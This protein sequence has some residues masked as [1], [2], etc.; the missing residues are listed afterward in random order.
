MNHK[1]KLRRFAIWSFV[2]YLVVFLT[3]VQIISFV[4]VVQDIGQDAVKVAHAST[5]QYIYITDESEPTIEDVKSEI[6]EQAELF[7]VDIHFA[8]D[9]ADCES[10][11]IWDAKN[12]N[13]TG[14]GVYQYLI[15]TWEETESAKAGKERND[16]K[17]NTREAMLDLANGEYWRW[18]ECIDII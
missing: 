14:R 10:D 3:G 18:Q 16:Y 9:L 17:A 4:L 13:S 11:F 15:G 7:G 1:K 2:F 5:V 6:R 12:P 8:L